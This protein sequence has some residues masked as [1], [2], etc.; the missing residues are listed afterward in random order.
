MKTFETVAGRKY[1]IAI[2]ISTAKKINAR[3]D[4]DMVND[5]E[6][7]V[8]RL[9]ADSIF[10]VDVLYVVCEKQAESYG[11][12]DEEFGEAMAGDVIKIARQALLD[13]VCDFFPGG[14]ERGVVNAAIRRGTELA[15]MLQK[16][17]I[18]IM[19]ETNVDRLAEQ[20]IHGGSSTSV[21][22]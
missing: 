20:L 13:G 1:D 4:V 17:M 18:Q 9:I 10:M 21:Q 15:A 12:N 2:N 5:V 7:F 16:Q 19:E 6:S 14:D 8:T 11:V 3:F 22:G